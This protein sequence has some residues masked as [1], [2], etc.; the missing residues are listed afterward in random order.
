MSYEK[1]KGE[2]RGV[3]TCI[4]NPISAKQPHMSL[5]LAGEAKHEFTLVQEEQYKYHKQKNKFL[6]LYLLI[7]NTK[8]GRLQID[9]KSNTYLQHPPTMLTTACRIILIIIIL[10]DSPIRP[11]HITIALTTN[12]S[13]LPCIRIG[14]RNRDL[15]VRSIR[16]C[17]RRRLLACTQHLV[18]R[19]WHRSGRDK[20]RWN[21]AIRRRHSLVLMGIVHPIRGPIPCHS[22]SSRHFLPWTPPLPI[23]T[24]S[25][26]SCVD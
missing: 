17:T 15:V 1:K 19:R 16:L 7:R 20:S 11:T 22:A 18:P 4:S 2:Q 9:E 3:Y 24:A 8:M 10:L 25:S 21:I 26:S 23:P 12:G 5:T 14:D 6:F 13:S